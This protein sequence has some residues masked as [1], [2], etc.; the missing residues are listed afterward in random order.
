MRA[1]KWA[2]GGFLAVSFI[3]ATGG[4][5]EDQAPA[6]GS[7]LVDIAPEP[8][9]ANCPFG[10][11]AV[12]WGVD[13]DRNGVLDAPEVD[14]TEFRCDEE[15]PGAGPQPRALATTE[16]E[17]AGPN[18]E[19]GGTAV[20]SGL[21]LDLDGTLDEEEVTQTIYVCET[22][23]AVLTR[24]ARVAPGASC[25]FGGTAVHS[26]RDLDRDAVLDDEEIESTTYVCD[27]AGAGREV[28]VVAGSRHTCARKS[29]G[30]VW[31]WGS[32]DSYQLGSFVVPWMSG[33]VPILGVANAKALAAGKWHTCAVLEG[34][35]LWCWGNNSDEQ[36]GRPSYYDNR[37]GPVAG[38]PPMA[39]VVAGYGH[40][41]GLSE[42]GTVWCWG[43]DTYAQSGRGGSYVSVGP[44]EIAGL[45]DVVALSSGSSFV[46]AL[47]R[48][49]EVRC[50]GRQIGGDDGE[51]CP[52]SDL[53]CHRQPTLVAELPAAVSIAAGG[54][55][56]CA[57]TEGGEAWCWGFNWTGVLGDG[58]EVSRAFAAPVLGL[59]DADEISVG[60]EH[61]CAV[62]GDGALFCWG[63]N[64]GG[65]LG[66]GSYG[67]GFAAPQQVPGAAGI[68]SL[69]LGDYYG[70]GLRAGAAH[71]WGK[72][73]H[74]QVSLVAQPAPVEVLN[75][76]TDLATG[77]HSAC[78]VRGGGAVW[79]WGAFAYGEQSGLWDDVPTLKEGLPPARDVAAG[80]NHACI[81]AVDGAIWCWGGNSYGEL[82][83]SHRS[84]SI[85]PL[86]VTGIDDAKAVYAGGHHSCAERA[87]GS[88]WCWG[89]DGHLFGF[90]RSPTEILPKVTSVA[91]TD[92]HGCAVDDT[93]SSWCWGNNRYRQVSSRS[94]SD[95]LPLTRV[96]GSVAMVSVDY[97]ESCAL[98]LDGSYRCWGDDRREHELVPIGE[99]TA[100]ESGYWHTCATKPDATMVC[101]GSNLQGQ[102][103]D[104]TLAYRREPVAV[105]GLTDVVQFSAGYQQSCARRA[106]GTV[107]CWGS[108]SAGQIGHGG[109]AG[110]VASPMLVEL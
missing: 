68:T 12:R 106:D 60:G 19:H 108:N 78:A 48:G 62:R 44:A 76:A 11:V 33:P 53:P 77:N 8:R 3:F 10:G 54:A 1:S 107:W 45:S 84:P 39:D 18:C 43:D 70:C 50:W 49:G 7:S 95:V 65:A 26:G 93:G 56:A 102:L 36:L 94:F 89:T 97:D 99:I 42:G 66:L 87:N 46:C 109:V 9:G 16:V 85:I 92:L 23:E 57:I 82:G 4:C 64:F 79:C 73:D 63:S 14:E 31:C 15:E 96:L 25:A 51:R 38:L 67:G 75:D 103:G 72:N 71:C 74:G 100:V 98:L 5:G 32:N 37:P 88:L 40:T 30:A 91:L 21:D 104:G 34:G 55:S 58:T 80:T 41:C 59:A 22:P 13:D 105:S 83:V 24:V 61:A 35:A 27:D 6:Q 81:A 52:P 28:E 20:H 29:S 86:R 47:Q 110:M 101:R 90:G 17:P 2:W 69:S